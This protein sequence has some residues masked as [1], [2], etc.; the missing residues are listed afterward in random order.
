MS[1]CYDNLIGIRGLCD[2]DTAMYYLDDYDMSLLIAS[3]VVDE[4][5]ITG[6]KLIQ[7]KINQAWKTVFSEF[8]FI[9]FKTN[10]I[11]EE[12]LFKY[13]AESGSDGNSATLSMSDTNV[14]ASLFV[15][16][17]TLK[18]KK[19]G[20]TNII[21][22]EN[23]AETLLFSGEVN[24]DTDVVVDLRRY[25][26]DSFSVSY[27][28]T[29]IE[30]YSGVI[31]SYCCRKEIINN[32]KYSN[33][34]EIA[35]QLRCN[36]EKY[37]CKYVD[38]LAIAVVYKALALIWNEVYNSNRLNN[39]VNL[40]REDAI[41]KMAF[42]DSTFNL[43]KYDIQAS[44]NYNP[45]GMYQMEIERLSIPAPRCNKCLNHKSDKYITSIP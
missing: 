10:T 9:G 30:V 32:N 36:L 42:Y 37:L 41:T 28:N 14:L 29:E 34:F 45:K 24:D 39:V 17:I 11:I 31:S 5:Y 43:L 6:R 25:V 12:L 2:E 27:D 22:N 18:V 26:S 33:G 38:L 13:D 20:T 35:L 3:K 44:V 23:G 15:E 16:K 8:Q 21:L 7:S 40:K 1:N 19:G 4:R